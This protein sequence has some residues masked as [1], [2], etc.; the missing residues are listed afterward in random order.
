M[1]SEQSTE[2]TASAQNI[3][4]TRPPPLKAGKDK[5]LL[6]PP[7][8][9]QTTLQQSLVGNFEDFKRQS[10]TADKDALNEQNGLFDSQFIVGSGNYLEERV[11]IQRQAQPI[12]ANDDEDGLLD[13][14]VRHFFSFFQSKRKKRGFTSNNLPESLQKIGFFQVLCSFF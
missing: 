11:Y 1:G 13:P 12:F 8:N 3:A 6:G 7:P 2:Q 4:G 10:K 5:D 9:H 14:D